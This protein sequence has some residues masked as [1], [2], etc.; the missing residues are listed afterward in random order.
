MICDE[1]VANF[2]T[3]FTFISRLFYNAIARDIT[4]Q[5]IGLKDDSLRVLQDRTDNIKNI[6]NWIEWKY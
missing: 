5:A 6:T 3:D 1:Y 4:Q 2:F